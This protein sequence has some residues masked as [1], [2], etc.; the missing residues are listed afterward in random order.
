MN[1]K[2]GEKLVKIARA[3]I[4]SE[5]IKFEIKEKIGI[6]VTIYSYPEKELR[7]CIG[8]IEPIYGLSEGVY[9]TAKLAAFNDNSIYNMFAGLKLGDLYVKQTFSCL[10]NF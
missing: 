2:D 5:K 7:G 8:F 1:L 10:N 3:A 6:F 4:N 9:N